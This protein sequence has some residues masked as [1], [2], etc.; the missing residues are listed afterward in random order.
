MT[1]IGLGSVIGR[2]GISSSETSSV[3]GMYV[4]GGLPDVGPS[5]E[6]RPRSDLG[7][8][9]CRRWRDEWRC[10]GWK[11]RSLGNRD[12]FGLSRE[13]QPLPS[14]GTLDLNPVQL[15]IRARH[16]EADGLHGC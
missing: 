4:T 13:A 15:G 6:A 5:R 7:T 16:P 8:P 10:V 11:D 2:S 14:R 9:L 3:S 12:W 1:G